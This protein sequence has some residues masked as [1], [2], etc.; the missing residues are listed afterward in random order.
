MM[1][2]VVSDTKSFTVVVSESNSAPVLGLVPN[3]TVNEGTLLS[4]GLSASDADGPANTLSYSLVSGPSGMTVSAASGLL[5]WTPSEAQGPSTN[6]VSVKVTDNGTPAFSDTRTF[7]VVVNEV[8]S[9]PVLAAVANQTVNEGVML[10]VALSGSDPDA[11][12]NGLSYSLVSGPS[13]M[14]VNAA[15]G[16]LSWT[17]GEAQGLSTNTITVQLTDNGVPSFSDSKT[18]TVIVNEVNR[19][20][21]LASVDDQAISESTLFQLQFER[22]RSGHA[23]QSPELYPRH[24]PCGIERE[25]GRTIRLAGWRDSSGGTRNLVTVR[26]SDDGVPSLSDSKSFYIVVSELNSAPVAVRCVRSNHQRGGDTQCQ[27]GRDDPDFPANKLIL[28]VGDG[29]ARSGCQSDGVVTWS[30]SPAD[31]GRSLSFAVEVTDNGLPRLSAARNFN[32]SV[33]GLNH[34]PALETIPDQRVKEGDVLALNLSATDPDL[35]ADS[36]T[37][38]LV[39]GPAGM[40][41]GSVSGLLSW[42]PTEAQGPSTNLVTV[43]VTDHGVPVLNDTWSF[44][45]VVTEVNSPPLLAPTADKTV[46][47]SSRLE[48]GLAAG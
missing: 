32:I 18:F 29:T 47:V 28:P 3:Q 20:P 21:V 26:L 10:S 35:P 7:T 19:S 8:N 4:V 14:S 16:L 41:V 9:A 38:S 37:Y 23:C 5:T 24:R 13:G 42:T 15:S 39:K 2:A 45:V 48:F 40:T 11:P 34:P 33:T 6:V 1:G 25:R 44:E 31:A 27:V 46:K 43:K 22:L 12:A 30:P 36:L 17:P